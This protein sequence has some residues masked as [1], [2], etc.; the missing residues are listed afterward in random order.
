V[1]LER[2]LPEEEDDPGGPFISPPGPPVPPGGPCIVLA[3]LEDLE[4]LPVVF[5]L[6]GGILPEPEYVVRSRVLVTE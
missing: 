2:T 5:V 4:E 1:I 6:P 3:E